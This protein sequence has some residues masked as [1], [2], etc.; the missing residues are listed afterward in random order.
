MFRMLS[1]ELFFFLA[2]QWLVYFEFE[3]S[4]LSMIGAGADKFF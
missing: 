4:G 2:I 3:L 1:L